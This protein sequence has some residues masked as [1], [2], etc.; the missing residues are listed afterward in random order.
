[1]VL[2]PIPKAMLTALDHIVLLT[3]D[4]GAAVADYETLFGGA[5]DWQTEDAMFRSALF[6]S[7]NIAL[8]IM[9]PAPGGAAEDRVHDILGERTSALT[10]LVFQSGDLDRAHHIA[11]RRGL[12]PSGIENGTSTDI[13]SGRSRAW[14]RFRCDDDVCAGIKTFILEP[15]TP[16]L[17][18]KMPNG[19]RLDHAVINTPNPERAIAHYGARLGIRFALD[20]TIEKFRTR[21]L[22]FKIGDVVLEVIDRMDAESAPAGPDSI[23]GLTWAVGDL[24]QAHA[25]LTKTGVNVSDIRTGRKPGTQVF[26]ARSHTAGIPT[27]FLAQA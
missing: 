17:K 23:W 6:Q 12:N 2:S 26:T 15:E 20:R 9:A 19:L 13:D 27:L 18:A 5:P 4:F 16:G 3:R 1:M 10:S 22:F 7:R 25:R 21:F 14:R 11:A 8:E 24:E